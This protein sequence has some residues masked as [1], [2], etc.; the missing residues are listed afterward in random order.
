MTK[1]EKMSLKSNHSKVNKI[2]TQPIE[3][4]KK[5]NLKIEGLQTIVCSATL[6]M[7]A[8]GRIWPSK[9]ANKSKKSK[10]NNFDAMEELFK[11]IRFSSKKPKNINLTAELKM[12]EKLVEFYHRC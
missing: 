1:K 8:Q 6:Q 11:R 10:R 4:E 3:G 7:D 9:K 12:P 5:L 2:K